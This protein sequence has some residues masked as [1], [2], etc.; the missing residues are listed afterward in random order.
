MTSTSPQIDEAFTSNVI[1]DANVTSP[2]GIPTV[3]KER[4]TSFLLHEPGP[5]Q[6][7]LNDK[8]VARCT[9][10]TDVDDGE[11]K[12]NGEQ[13]DARTTFF[14]NSKRHLGLNVLSDHNS[15]PSYHT[16]PSPRIPSHVDPVSVAQRHTVPGSTY[17]HK[18]SYQEN[19]MEISSEYYERRTRMNDW[20]GNDQMR[21]HRDTATRVTFPRRSSILE[22]EKQ[23]GKR[24]F[25]NVLNTL[26]QSRT[27]INA[28]RKRRCTGEHRHRKPEVEELWENKTRPDEAGAEPHWHHDAARAER[29][30]FKQTREKE[31]DELLVTLESHSQ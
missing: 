20:P 1:R 18:H 15:N 5:D 11:K 12:D 7:R 16:D 17:E 28:E 10:P 6:C 26:N 23:R 27:E 4:A 24:L 3:D 25:S 2:N 21:L 22:E 31:E 19:D 30:R 14:P 9:I 29:A 8:Q 13:C